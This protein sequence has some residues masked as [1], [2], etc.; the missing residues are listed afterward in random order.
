[1]KL[2]QQLKIKQNQSLIM[3]PQLQQAIKLLQLTNIE[4]AD[5]IEKTQLENPFL[6]EK[7]Q[8]C[9]KKFLNNDYK[10]QSVCDNMISSLDPYKKESKVDI[11]NTFDTHISSNSKLENKKLYDREIIK[12][13]N[14]AS[15]GE[16]IEKT[17]KY[18]VSL[19]EYIINQIILTDTLQKKANQYDRLFISE[20]VVYCFNKEAAKDLNVDISVAERT[21][22]LKPEPQVYFTKFSSLFE[23]LMTEN[24]QLDQHFKISPQ[25]QLLPSGNLNRLVNFAKL[26]KNYLE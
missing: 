11:E 14:N 21:R 7:S 25:S 8:S 12:S 2:G 15:A 23:N 1:M 13:G 26:K 10:N 9:N 3:T 16:I 19:R 17:L 5:F 20:W 18:E 6:R 22:K 24:K 4:L